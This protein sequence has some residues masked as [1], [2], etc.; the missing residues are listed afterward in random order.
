MFSKNNALLLA[1]VIS[2]HKR[3]LLKW[4]V[5]GMLLKI[6]HRTQSSAECLEH[7]KMKL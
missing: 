3:I 7:N 6:I 4:K 1:I 5:L 2:T